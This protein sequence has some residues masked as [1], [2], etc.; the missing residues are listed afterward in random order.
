MERR[1]VLRADV[2][3]RK[4]RNENCEQEHLKE[5][6]TTQVEHRTYGTGCP[7]ST[8][9]SEGVLVGGLVGSG[10]GVFVRGG[11]QYFKRRTL[12]STWSNAVPVINTISYVRDR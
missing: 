4:E 10:V 9:D 3:C 11:L 8:G 12:A 2:N 1:P 6:S 7:L 5:D